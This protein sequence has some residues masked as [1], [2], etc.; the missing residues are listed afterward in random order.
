LN[1]YLLTNNLLH[2]KEYDRSEWNE[3]RKQRLLAINNGFKAI[4]CC[5]NIALG[6]LIKQIYT[7]TPADKN[8][9]LF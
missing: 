8:Y 5:Y 4:S 6:D 9:E 3:Y 7:V 1:I 2:K